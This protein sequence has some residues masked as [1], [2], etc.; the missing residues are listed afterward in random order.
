M[1]MMM[2]FI[3]SRCRRNFIA[4]Q[5]IGLVPFQARDD[6]IFDS[7]DVVYWYLIQ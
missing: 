7:D 5:P 4:T 2:S 6:G 1:M 3:C